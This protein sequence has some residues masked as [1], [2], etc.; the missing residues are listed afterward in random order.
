MIRHRSGQK[1]QC[2]CGGLRDFDLGFH[3]E[4]RLLRMQ[5]ILRFN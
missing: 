1:G 3:A 5:L 2:L 4:I